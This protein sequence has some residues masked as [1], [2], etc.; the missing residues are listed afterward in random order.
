MI[1]RIYIKSATNKRWSICKLKQL[2]KWVAG[3][4]FATSSAVVLRTM[5]PLHV[6]CP[7]GRVTSS[8]RL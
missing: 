4:R 8:S 7:S 3:L 5:A 6:R 1:Q 2:R